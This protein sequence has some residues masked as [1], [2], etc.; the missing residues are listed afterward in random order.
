MSAR[1]A[2]N[3]ELTRDMI[4]KAARD[5]FVEKGFQQAS[6]R[7]IAK[8]LD[9]SHGAIYYHFKNKAELFYALVEDHFIMLDKEIND[10]VD[11]KIDDSEKLKQLFLGYI[12]FGLTHQSHYEIMFLVKD[13]EVR[14]FMNVSPMKTY[15]KFANHVAD[16]SEKRISVQ[17]I[18][19][20]FLSLHGFVTHYLHHVTNFKEA[21]G[22]ADFHANMLLKWTKK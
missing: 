19:S 15:Q 11:Q 18:W 8:K 7:Q 20:I 9:Y 12:E 21:K 17:E 1:K 2:V 14:N 16:L 5:L 6:M 22:M 13:D 10:L 4:M 3:K